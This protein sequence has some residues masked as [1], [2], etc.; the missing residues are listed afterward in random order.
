ML[1]CVALI[2]QVTIP[3]VVN[4]TLISAP[5]LYGPTRWP[6]VMAL[7]LV[8]QAES[9]S[10]PVDN[11][12]TTFGL[13]VIEGSRTIEYSGQELALMEWGGALRF[14]ML[15]T[16]LLNVLTAPRGLAP[17][18]HTTLLTLFIAFVC[19]LIVIV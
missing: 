16:I 10:I 2:A 9:G 18:A 4:Q 14:F 3:F 17:E 11:P 15:L 13:S 1:F 12:S 19:C 7:F 6:L 8:I 5:H